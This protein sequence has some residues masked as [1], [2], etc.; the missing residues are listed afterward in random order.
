MD[1]ESE[2]LVLVSMFLIAA[3]FYCVGR[4]HGIVKEQERVEEI[5]RG[6]DA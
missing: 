1:A 3:G 5:I 4:L 2:V 6:H